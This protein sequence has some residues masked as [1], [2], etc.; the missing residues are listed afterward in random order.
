LILNN[1]ELLIWKERGMVKRERERGRQVGGQTGQQ[2]GIFKGR[3]CLREI[4]R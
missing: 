3:F 1:R 4:V 2:A